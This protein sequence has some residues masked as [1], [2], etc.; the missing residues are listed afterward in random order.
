MKPN[1]LKHSFTAFQASKG[2]LRVSRA[3]G[4][5]DGGTLGGIFTRK[6]MDGAQILVSQNRAPLDA[7][8]KG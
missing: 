5:N 3:V 4:E 7:L 8:E 1:R 2:R 6:G